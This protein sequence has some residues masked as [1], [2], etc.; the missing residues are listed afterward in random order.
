MIFKKNWIYINWKFL[1]IDISNPKR[2]MTKIKGIFKPLK[3]YF[4]YEKGDYAPNPILWVSKPNYIQIIIH[5]VLWKD[6]YDTP[7]FECSPYVWIHIF[8][9]NWVWYWSLPLHQKHGED[10]YWEQALWYL[11]Y[12]KTISQFVID[13][14]DIKVAK[15]S[16]PWQDMKGNSTWT[17]EFL[18]K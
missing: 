1:Y 9:W 6:K 15:E 7:R 14:P 18:V 8:K 17:D 4:K 3:C 16:W 11:Y 13:Y 2:T 10:E 12:H 5:D